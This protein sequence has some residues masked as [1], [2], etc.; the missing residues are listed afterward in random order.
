MKKLRKYIKYLEDRI[1]A[2]KKT[3]IIYSILRTLVI[4]CAVRQLVM[5]HYESFFTCI[6]ALGL[7]LIPSFLEDHFKIEIPTLFQM[8]I[9]VFIFSTS[10]LGEVDAF[11]TKIPAWDSILHTINGFL[12]AAV[13]FSLVDLLNRHSDRVNLSPFYLAV[14]AFCFSMTIGVLWE[15]FECSCDLFLGTDMQK[16]FIIQT[17]H[18]VTLDP[19]ASQKVI[20]VKN[21]TDTLIHTADGQSV[22]IQGGYLDI[23][24][25]DTMKDLF[26]NFIGAVVFSVIG[27]FYVSGREKAGRARKIAKSLIIR[28]MN[29]ENE[30]FEEDVTENKEEEKNPA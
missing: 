6:M 29:E 26:V 28:K 30:V 12:A 25:L 13:G 10:I 27:Y 17:I 7:F 5:H 24:L 14:T 19:T 9:Y 23:G 8:A 2:D 18:S 20:T 22:T 15:F 1:K 21:I 16:D 3:F 11:Y 4:L